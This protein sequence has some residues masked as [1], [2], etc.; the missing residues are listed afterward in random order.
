MYKYYVEG[1]KNIPF[2]ISKLIVISSAETQNF[3]KNAEIYQADVAQKNDIYIVIE[4][5]K[6]ITR[7][8]LVIY[9]YFDYS[10][11]RL[12]TIPPHIVMKAIKRTTNGFPV[13]KL[14]LVNLALTK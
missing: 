5:N 4:K 10:F 9:C 14:R 1:E 7:K 2:N 11:L 3:T 6:R 8:N 13:F 12:S